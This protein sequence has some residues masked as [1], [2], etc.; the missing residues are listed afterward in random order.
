MGKKATIHIGTPKTG[1]TAI[2]EFLDTNRAALLELGFAVPS[3]FGRNHWWL[4]LLCD[5]EKEWD[6]LTWKLATEGGW[7]DIHT[8]QWRS[9]VN[10]RRQDLKGFGENAEAD[11]LLFS[12]EHLYGRLIGVD[13]VGR[14]AD[15][16]HPFVDEVEILVYLREPL[17]YRVSEWSTVLRHGLTEDPLVL[18]PPG[19][20]WRKAP[21]TANWPRK[22][23]R[24]QAPMPEDYRARLQWWE[25]VFP[26]DVK[27]RIFDKDSWVEG[28][29]VRDFC[30]AVGIPWSDDFSI[31]TK[32]NR[33]FSWEMMKTLSVVNR[34]I[35]Q[36]LVDGRRDPARGAIT[37]LLSAGDDL[38]APRYLPSPAE[39]DAYE[40]FFAESNEWVRERYFPEKD[41]LWT[42]EI[43]L[44]DGLDSVE[45]SPVLGSRQLAVAD[46]SVRAWQGWIHP[47]VESGHRAWKLLDDARKQR[48]DARKQRDDARKQRDDARKQ[49]DDV[50]K[51]RDDVR[52]QRDE[53]AALRSEA[54]EQLAAAQHEL[55]SI[56]STRVWRYSEPYRNLRGRRRKNR[57][58]P[59]AE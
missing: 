58:Q 49:R 9:H 1:T 41:R 39:K 42:S 24:E 29:L 2:Q 53:L 34:E 59:D 31:P 57:R 28:S 20:Y 45:F 6:E 35:P 38:A 44:R 47:V 13:D 51:Q 10:R 25:E 5:P 54:L 21:F 23:E 48:D 32:M 27:V 43:R 16:M 55:A 40:E 18:P 37:E 46:F 17:S 50:R 56:K 12:A 36:W 15:L 22:A 11:H 19:R 4:P 26:N 33:S 7:Q 8:H 3:I 30:D 14:L 52:K